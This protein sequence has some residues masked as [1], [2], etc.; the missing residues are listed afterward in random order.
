MQDITET[1]ETK[2]SDQF[3]LLCVDGK[4]YLYI[5]VKTDSE[6]YVDIRQYVYTA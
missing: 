5:L 1:G 2:M 6:V 3:N 4:Y